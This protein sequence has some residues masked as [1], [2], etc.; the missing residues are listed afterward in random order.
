MM[1]Y[2]GT[3]SSEPFSYSPTL[4]CM[5]DDELNTKKNKKKRGDNDANSKLCH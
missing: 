4:L 1:V 5:N 2:N 3:S